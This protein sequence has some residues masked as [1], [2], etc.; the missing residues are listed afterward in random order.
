MYGGALGFAGATLGL[1][2]G[3]FC[4]WL[5]DRFEVIQL[6]PELSAIY[7]LSAVPF[8]VRWIDLFAVLVFTLG[9]TLLACWVPARRAMRV[10]PS[11]ALRYE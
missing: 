1:A 7:F 5:M 2:F 9:V 8:Q 10:Q 4:A 6:G 3:S 11:V